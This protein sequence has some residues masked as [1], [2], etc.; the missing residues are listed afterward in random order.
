[1]SAI[2]VIGDLLFSRGYD[3]VIDQTQTGYTIFGYTKYIGALTSEPKW[4][5]L[6]LKTTNSNKLN[7]FRWKLDTEF[8]K[9]WSTTGNDDVCDYNF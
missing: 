9:I 7:W 8:N 4:A 3:V 1:M 2:Q 5:L 6:R